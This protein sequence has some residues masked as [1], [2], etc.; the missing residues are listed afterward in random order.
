VNRNE[1]TVEDRLRRALAIDLRALHEG[2]DMSSEAVTVRIRELAEL[3]SLC[4]E[5]GK[6]RKSR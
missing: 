3:S 5:L 2:I 6:A 4:V 1:T